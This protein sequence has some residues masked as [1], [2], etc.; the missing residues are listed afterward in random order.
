[1]VDYRDFF[2]NQDFIVKIIQDLE[3]FNAIVNYINYHN[4]K[5]Q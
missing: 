3:R 4:I 1:M 5:L 2:T